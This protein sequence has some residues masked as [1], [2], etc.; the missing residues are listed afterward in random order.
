MLL[1]LLQRGVFSQFFFSVF[2]QS[3]KS[4]QL[5]KVCKKI[6]GLGTNMTSKSVMALSQASSVY[7]FAQ[8]R[9]YIRE[10]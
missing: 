1:G 8:K 5:V 4:H 6:T 3:T 7:A 10:K 2:S 9:A